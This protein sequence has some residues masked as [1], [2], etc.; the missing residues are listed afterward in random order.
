MAYKAKIKGV[1][2]IAY[3]HPFVLANNPQNF[4]VIDLET[5]TQEQ[6]AFV[7]EVLEHGVANV[8]V[9][10]ISEKAPKADK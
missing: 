1:V 10:K 7:Y 5:A 3:N 9:E 8:Q 4:R 2:H 6:L